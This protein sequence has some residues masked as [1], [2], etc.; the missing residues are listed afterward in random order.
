M[1]SAVCSSS[2]VGKSFLA[3]KIESSTKPPLV[4]HRSGISIVHTAIMH[5]ETW[6]LHE[7]PC[8]EEFVL[9]AGSHGADRPHC[10]E[11]N[12]PLQQVKELCPELNVKRQLVAEV[13]YSVAHVAA[14]DSTVQCLPRGQVCD[15]S[16]RVSVRSQQVVVLQTVRI[17]ALAFLQAASCFHK[18]DPW[19]F[20]HLLGVAV[21]RSWDV[22]QDLRQVLHVTNLVPYAVTA[23]PCGW[24]CCLS[25]P[26]VMGPTSN[27]GFNQVVG[28]WALL[29]SS[30]TSG[31]RAVTF[32]SGCRI[33]PSGGCR[34][35]RITLYASLP[36]FVHPLWSLVL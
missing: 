28:C 33:A 35:S 36:P 21:V 22:Q 12:V 3:L 23:R 16:C 17:W 13:V 31:M 20:R 5:G 24:R 32:P 8:T 10:V 34:S 18:Q 2:S 4:S 30:G 7:S 19:P 9:P 26:L 25:L 1:S 15:R 29:I 27:C 14:P 6:M 11:A